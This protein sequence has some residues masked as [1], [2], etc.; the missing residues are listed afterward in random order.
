MAKIKQDKI[1]LFAF[2]I[3]VL[4]SV[5]LSVCF[6]SLRLSQLFMV[7]D[8]SK[9]EVKLDDK[10]NP[11]YATAESLAR[12]PSIGLVRAEAIISYRE[13]FNGKNGNSPVFQSCYDLQKIKGL[14]PKITKNVNRWLKFE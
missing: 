9:C 13:N 1:Q 6:A 10:L 7:S 8:C 5:C 3:A 12:L 4:I 14:G 2:V 11:N